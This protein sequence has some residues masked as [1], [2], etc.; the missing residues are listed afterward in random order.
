M[1]D[2][3]MTKL[4]ELVKA[5][6]G[7]IFWCSPHDGVMRRVAR[8]VP[9]MVPADPN[10]LPEPSDCAIFDDSRGHGIAGDY[11]CLFF[12]AL[13]EFYICEPITLATTTN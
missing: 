6:P 13:S 10:D 2:N 12:Q 7:R 8:I 3:E 1:E 5:N 11:V 9:P 4:T